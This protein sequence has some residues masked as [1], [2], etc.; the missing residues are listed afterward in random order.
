[1]TEFFH[2]IVILSRED[3]YYS[4]R[5]NLKSENVI[6]KQFSLTAFYRLKTRNFT[7][8]WVKNRVKRETGDSWVVTCHQEKIDNQTKEK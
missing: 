1:M 3:K 7:T 4:L 6:P 2:F 5:S 8:G